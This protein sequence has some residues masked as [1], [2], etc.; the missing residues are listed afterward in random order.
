PAVRRKYQG[1]QSRRQEA[2]RGRQGGRHQHGGIRPGTLSLPRTRQ[3]VGPGGNRSGAE[4]LCPRGPEATARAES[5]GQAEG[6]TETEG[7]RQAQGRGPAEGREKAKTRSGT[8][9]MASFK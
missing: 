3:G 8:S 9:V 2:G 7:R 6:R 1:R 5:R 4:V